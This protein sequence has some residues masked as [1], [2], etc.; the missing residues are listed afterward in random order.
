MNYTS[1]SE[2]KLEVKVAPYSF[3]TARARSKENVSFLG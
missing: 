2:R 1:G 3:T